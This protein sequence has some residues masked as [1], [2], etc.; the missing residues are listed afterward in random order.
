MK[1]KKLIYILIPLILIIVLATF[2]F[3][4]R[5]LNTPNLNAE[6]EKECNHEPMLYYEYNNRKIYSYCLSNIEISVNNEKIELKD[7]LLNNSLD[8][9]ISHLEK[10]SSYDDG[11]TT[12]YKDGGSKKITANGMTLIECK[13][14]EGNND[15]YIGPKD[16]KMKMNFCKSD[17]TTF[18]RTY[19]VDKVSNYTKQQ[20]EGEIPVTYSKSLEVTLHEENKEPVTVI[21]NNSAET[22]VAGKIYEFEFVIDNKKELKDNIES[23]FKNCLIVEIRETTKTGLA[24]RQDEIK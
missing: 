21:I 15:I 23:I 1:N 7:Y 6:T 2:I 19:I 9:L 17:N 10:L 13:T 16:M 8:S 11:G 3:Y 14:L 12:I 5:S 20:F 18:T 24:Q 4:K 22:P